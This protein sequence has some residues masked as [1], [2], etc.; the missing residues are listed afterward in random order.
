LFKKPQFQV[1]AQTLAILA[2]VFSKPP[3]PQ[4]NSGCPA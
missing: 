3:H 4:E 2:Y 1:S